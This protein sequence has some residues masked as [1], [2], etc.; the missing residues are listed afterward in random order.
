MMQ[1]TSQTKARWWPFGRGR[2]EQKSSIPPRYAEQMMFHSPGRPV[3]TQRQYQQLA[4][5]GYGRN[6]VAFRAV[7][8]IAQAAS[9]VGWF[10][11]DHTRQTR[12]ERHPA[13]TLLQK[14]NPTT[15]LPGL[16]ESLI[17]HRLIS[18]NS[19]LHAVGPVDKA[20]LEL[21]LLRPDRV[22]ILAGK[23]GSPLPAGYRYSHSKG[24]TDYPVHPATG[25]SRVLHWKHFHPLSDWY[26]MS[27]IEAAAY[28]IDQHNQAAAWNQSLLQNGARP[29]GALVVKS[30]DSNAGGR[31][32]EDQFQRL[33][34]QVDEQFSGSGNAG[35]PLLLE[36]G[37]DWTEMSISPKDMDFI[38]MKHSSARDIALAFGVPPQLLG[39]PGD[40]TYSN[41]AEARLALWEQTVL[42]LLDSLARSLNNW[43]MPMFMEGRP[44][45]LE[46]D[47]DRISALTPRRDA[48]WRRINEAT[49]LSDEE[50]KALL[51][52]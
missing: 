42:P 3:W 35:R 33:R 12:L 25:K 31:L 6:V 51:M 30:S 47:R 32:S 44:V 17:S 1:A 7:G 14:P 4:D 19:Y 18:G 45:E 46:Y 34:S 21:H 39:I 11:H 5:E 36:G 10:A 41:L 43:L 2:T 38:E 22:K 37:L 20:P 28:S 23:Q 13:L 50:K 48:Y 16:V 8:M 26:G 29:S 40:N 27:P 24:E 9:S 52:G 15:D 49:F